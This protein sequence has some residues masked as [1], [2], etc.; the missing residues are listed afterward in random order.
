VGLVQRLIDP[1][2]GAEEAL[3]RVLR[4]FLAAAPKAAR[5]TRELLLRIAPLPDPDLAEFAAATIAAARTSPEGQEGL[6][7]F[8]GKVPPPWAIPPG[9]RQV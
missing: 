2:E 4:E 9:E 1:R 6:K 7:A 5:A 3:T 8:F